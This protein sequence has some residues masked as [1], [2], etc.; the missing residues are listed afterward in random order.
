MYVRARMQGE[1]DTLRIQ[2]SAPRILEQYLT[3]YAFIE[4]QY[5]NMNQLFM[6]AEDPR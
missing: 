5:A 1:K 6:H 3:N 4:M 2:S